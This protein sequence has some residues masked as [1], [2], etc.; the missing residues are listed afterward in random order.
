MLCVKNVADIYSFVSLFFSK[1]KVVHWS[2]WREVS[3]ELL[4]MAK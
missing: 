4:S 3:G 1:G 2:S